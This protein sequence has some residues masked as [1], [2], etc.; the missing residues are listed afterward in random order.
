MAH[1]STLSRYETELNLRMTVEADTNGL[2]RVLDELTLARAD[3]EMQI[4]NLKEELAFLKK[5]H[6]EVR[7]SW[8]CRR[9]SPANKQG[10]GS[11]IFLGQ[12]HA[13]SLVLAL[14]LGD[15]QGA[16]HEAWRTLSPQRYFPCPSR[17]DLLNGGS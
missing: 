10:R 2:R 5:N 13:L 7:L 12:G 17:H 16:L 3:L 1:A 4:E 9:N 11:Q 6:E 14:N 8:K 15:P